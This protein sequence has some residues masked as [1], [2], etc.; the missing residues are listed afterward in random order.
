MQDKGESK[1]HHENKSIIFPII[2]LAAYIASLVI[3]SVIG[4]ATAIVYRMKI[5]PP[6]YFFG[7]WGLIYTL[8]GILLIYNVIN[9]TWRNKTHVYMTLVS[10]FNLAWI[11]V[12]AS[13]IEGKVFIML[14][15]LILVVFSCFQV[16][17]RIHR[18]QYDSDVKYLA[19]RNTISLYLG[20][21]SAAAVLNFCQMLIYGL[22]VDEESTAMAFWVV[23]IPVAASFIHYAYKKGALDSFIGYFF[24]AA[25]G[26]FGVYTARS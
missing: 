1:R 24:S 20:W 25:W 10:L 26:M 3:N 18:S 15:I 14:A 9:N 23:V 6:A 21:V 11:Q 5:T 19:A 4:P 16:W 7:I 13:K 22:G 2:S 12:T 17:K 8:A